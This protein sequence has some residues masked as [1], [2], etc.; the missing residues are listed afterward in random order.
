MPPLRILICHRH[1]I[2]RSGLR[3][4]LEPEPGIRIVAEAAN[5]AEALALTDYWRPDIVILDLNLTQM[6]GISAAREIIRKGHKA[7]IVFVT[8]Y[9]DEEYIAEAFKAG[10][11][12]F[13]LAASAQ[14]DLIHAVRAVAQERR[15]LSPG[16][17][18][19]LQDAESA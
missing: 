12:A 13:V 6:T 10:A 9:S 19:K 11:H 7:R 8:G 14:T 17:T 3:V 5:G 4:L 1:P 16:L 2:V 18:S 15:F